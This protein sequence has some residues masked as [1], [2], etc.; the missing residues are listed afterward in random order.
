MGLSIVIAYTVMWLPF[1]IV[2][3]SIE[4]EAVWTHDH[5]LLMP[6]SYGAYALQYINSAGN[7]FLYMFLTDSFRK[8]S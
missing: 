4:M 2:Q 3:W 8:V 1:W 5:T 7:P 6:I